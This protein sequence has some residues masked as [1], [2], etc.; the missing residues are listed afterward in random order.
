MDIHQINSYLDRPLRL[1]DKHREKVALVV[2]CAISSCIFINVYNPLNVNDIEIQSW[3]GFT[4][5][6]GLCGIVG[7][8][9]LLFTQFI[10]RPWF[11]VSQMNIRQFVLWAC[12]ELFVISLVILFFYGE[13]GQSLIQ[14]YFVTARLAVIITIVP[15]MLSCLLIALILKESTPDA[16]SK[17]QG[18]I[19]QDFANLLDANGKTKLV[20]KFEDLI[21][22]KAQ[23]NYVQVTYLLNGSTEKTLIR[24]SMKSIA[25]GLDE[26]QFMRIHRSHLINKE[27]IKSVLQQ[28]GKLEVI[29]SHT[30]D[31][32]LPVSSTYRATLNRQFY[33]QISLA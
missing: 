28:N 31:R 21:C 23:D 18:V 22:L 14:E 1:L 2:L 5:P 33:K 19:L 20:V 7:A 32:P 25:Q 26:S 15:Y 13:T 9:T 27:H 11:G 30:D 3:L 29:M 12:L 6:V 24:T 17:R 10:L 16:P 4:L 8:A